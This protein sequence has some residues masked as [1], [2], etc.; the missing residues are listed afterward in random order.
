MLS[1]AR[2]WSRREMVLLPGCLNFVCQR[3]MRDCVHVH[4]GSQKA[5]L[6]S[7]GL[8]CRLWRFELF[9]AHVAR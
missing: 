5:G 8:V 1:F 6:V 7:S 2:G 9:L 4:N 3:L